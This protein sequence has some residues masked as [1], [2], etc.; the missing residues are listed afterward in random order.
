MSLEI[1]T[2]Y[3]QNFKFKHVFRRMHGNRP[4][5]ELD[6]VV[7]EYTSNFTKYSSLSKNK[8]ELANKS[9]FLFINS[10][11]QE[12]MLE[13][14]LIMDFDSN[15]II[16]RFRY[17]TKFLVLEENIRRHYDRMYRIMQEF[18]KHLNQKK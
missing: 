8:Q 2:H 9:A 5:Y 6:H 16:M 11:I 18:R 3:K 1:V 15:Q 7:A 12:E 13:K 4:V 17:R 10:I 14:S